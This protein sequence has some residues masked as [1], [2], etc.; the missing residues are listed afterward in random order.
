MFAEVV[1]HFF[2]SELWYEQR[3]G[4]N[5]GDPAEGERCQEERAYLELVLLRQ[6]REVPEFISEVVRV[7]VP[8]GKPWASYDEMTVS[9]I[10]DAA[11]LLGLVPET[12]AY[13]QEQLQRQD[14]L[15]PLAVA[16]D[17]LSD[18]ERSRAEPS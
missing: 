9:E 14:V 12:V 10:V 1:G 17:A 8:A 15:A 6:C 18:T 5:G 3:L 4:D 13:E 2:D 7:R 16:L 11:Q